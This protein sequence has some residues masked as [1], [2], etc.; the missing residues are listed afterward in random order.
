MKDRK[1]EWEGGGEGKEERE[2]FSAWETIWDVFI[3]KREE[4]V[5]GW[6][7]WCRTVWWE[8]LSLLIF[9]K[10]FLFCLQ[11]SLLCC[12]PVEK[13]PPCTPLLVI[14]AQTLS[15]EDEKFK[16]ITPCVYC[17]SAYWHK[18]KLSPRAWSAF[19][20]QSLLF[21]WTGSKKDPMSSAS[22]HV[23][24]SFI[25][26]HFL[27]HCE[28]YYGKVPFRLEIVAAQ[29]A[30]GTGVGEVSH[31]SAVRVL[32]VFTYLWQEEQ[33]MTRACQRADHTLTASFR[34]WYWA[35]VWEADKAGF[36]FPSRPL[37]AACATS[38]LFWSFRFPTGQKRERFPCRM[39]WG[40]QETTSGGV[41]FTSPSPA[42]DTK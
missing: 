3:V 38:G 32:C 42:L 35:Q 17:S 11:K 26:S 8:I 12:W 30:E 34:A 24:N 41:L 21:S 28:P 40:V 19:I 7:W 6:V 27:N 29:S 13:K 9:C 37:T 33:P 2:Q 31:L 4:C 23:K 39:V 10:Y 5:Q 1:R 14:P 20:W 15:Y 22:H 18:C 25:L 36:G 16:A